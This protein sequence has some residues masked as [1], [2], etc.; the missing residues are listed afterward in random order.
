MLALLTFVQSVAKAQVDSV[1][2][3]INDVSETVPNLLFQ[4]VPMEGTIDQFT[5][6][7]KPRYQLKRKMG[8]DHNFIFHG[9]VFGHDTYFQA[10]YTRKSRTI[11]KVLVTPKNINEVAWLDSLVAHYG[12]PEDTPK[13]WLWQR[14]EGMILFYT[15]EGYDCALIYLDAKGNAL[16]KEEK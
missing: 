3:S 9:P 6:R 12:A 8:G 1:A 5:E 4:G 2:T 11:Y 10:S 7:L 16:F 13:G 15:P 14:P